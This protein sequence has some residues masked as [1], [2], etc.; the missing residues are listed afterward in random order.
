MVSSSDSGD[1]EKRKRKG[2]NL[3]RLKRS[4]RTKR[5]RCEAPEEK[6]NTKGVTEGKWRGG[7]KEE[8]RSPLVTETGQSNFGWLFLFLIYKSAGFLILPIITI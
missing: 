8:V 2:E 5:I 7:R 3:R 4:E 1:K 6:E